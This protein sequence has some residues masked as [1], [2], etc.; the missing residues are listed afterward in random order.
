MSSQKRSSDQAVIDE[1]Q[2]VID[3]AQ[4]RSTEDETRVQMKAITDI[5]Q[6]NKATIYAL[7]AI[8]GAVFLASGGASAV[9]GVVG[10]VVAAVGDKVGNF[11]RTI[12]EITENTTTRPT[13]V[14]IMLL[15]QDL[16]NKFVNENEGT[17][18]KSV[19]FTTDFNRAITQD[20]WLCIGEECKP[21]ALWVHL[22]VSKQL[23]PFMAN[24]IEMI[25]NLFPIIFN[26]GAGMTK[27]ADVGNKLT[28]KLAYGTTPG[29]FA[30]LEF[31]RKLVGDNDL[32]QMANDVIIVFLLSRALVKYRVTI[33]RRVGALARGGLDAVDGI[34]AFLASHLHDELPGLVSPGPEGSDYGSSVS[35][36]SSTLPSETQAIGV[37]MNATADVLVKIAKNLNKGAA[38]AGDTSSVSS[39]ESKTSSSKPTIERA[40]G[41]TITPV[42]A[43]VAELFAGFW[44]RFMRY[45]TQI[46]NAP[47]PSGNYSRASSNMSDVS[48]SSGR[49][50]VRQQLR[51]LVANGTASQIDIEILSSLLTIDD[52]CII[53]EHSLSRRR[54]GSDLSEVNVTDSQE[55]SQDT[56]GT[57]V[58][59][60]T[61]E[62]IDSCSEVNKEVL[63]VLSNLVNEVEAEMKTG[64]R[65]RRTRKHR[66][67]TKGRKTRKHHRVK[68]SRRPRK[69]RK[70]RKSRKY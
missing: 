30:I 47:V 28:R 69:S 27:L 50:L 1:A 40:I 20:D 68:K 26:S 6:A 67:S 53:D 2:A 49:S 59:E 70:G 13:E 52:E 7:F 29:F 38:S 10:G 66:K 45:T 17:Y 43:I 51:A 41:R 15:S 62:T 11:T 46:V 60:L 12:A 33:A 16:Q 55:N 32:L 8:A 18:T 19:E 25:L 42:A 21:L 35:T 9:G 24:S 34:V 36:M 57:G 48:T 63:G 64:G 5:E 39:D 56:I 3:E 37:L 58:S 44:N 22:Y 31:T 61:L 65:R 54:S 23:P 4:E 14:E